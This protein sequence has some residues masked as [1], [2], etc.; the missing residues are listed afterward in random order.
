[1]RDITQ[2]NVTKR[3]LWFALPFLA[4]NILQ[5]LYN[6]AA[7][8]IVGK[9]AGKQ[10]LAAVG[11]AAP[12]M[13]I[14]MFLMIGITLGT[15]VLISEFYGAKD[16]QKVKEEQA[17]ALVGGMLFSVAVSILALLFTRPLLRL[18][19]TPEEILPM[20]E[21]YLHII[22]A[23]LIFSFLYNL[24]ASSLRSVG[25][26][27]MPL[28]FLLISSVL[29]IGISIWL[30]RDCGLG[31]RGAAISTVVS[32]AVS[33][34]LCLL[35][36]RF[37]TPVLHVGL[38]QLKINAGMLAKT[39][40]YSSVSAVQQTF[41]YVG[42]FILQGAVN[43]LGVDAIAAYSAVTKIDGFILAPTD[44]LALALTIFTSTNRG[45]K[46]SGRIRSGL[47]SAFGIGQVY[48]LIISLCVY[49]L[50][51]TLML[52]FLEPH[53]TEAIAIG[54][55]YLRT[56]AFCYFFA[57][58]TNPCQGFFRGL[59][60]MKITLYATLIQIPMRLA[61]AYL[62]VP[63]FGLSV[64]ALAMAAGWFSMLVFELYQIRKYW[65]N[66]APLELQAAGEVPNDEIKHEPE[67][68]PNEEVPQ[69]LP[70]PAAEGEEKTE[71]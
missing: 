67:E 14:M 53:E 1:M 47:W 66:E 23:G 35:Y 20:A 56:I 54:I 40:Q 39:F 61:L 65:R 50:A 52:F 42:V 38:R 11:S 19:R 55:R 34:A 12:I 21:A 25:N 64:I 45:A 71:A 46:K 60:K 18:I 3:M 15:S 68:V 43:P 57:G 58:F 4:A 29:N 10:A 44:S 31:V 36:I 16:W 48:C 33:V 22:L 8:V 30:V 32:Q 41:L 6:T 28:V 13:N 2:G 7:L 24:L 62:L 17:T 59:G 26:A 27:G 69:E 51:P 49:L 63:Y 37:K 70:E 5:Q 9:Y